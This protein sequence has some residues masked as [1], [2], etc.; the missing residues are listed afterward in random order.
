MELLVHKKREGLREGVLRMGE[1]VAGALRKSIDCLRRQDLELAA[2]ILDEDQPIN[3]HR[4]MLEQ[5]SLVVLAAH[6]PAGRDLRAIGACL[7]LVAELERIA[8]YAA[9][10]AEIVLD[11]GGEVF[12]EEPRGRI[13]SLAEEA[14]AMVT[15]ALS[16]YKDSDAELATAAAG[17][18]D[19]V[20]AQE[21]EIIADLVTLMR[22]NGQLAGAGARLLWAVHLYE[23]VADRATNIAER[24]VFVV[25][26]ETPDLD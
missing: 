20:D 8:D 16:A 1:L 25:S 11:A 12:P 7:E 3:Q 19:A 13:V 14:T 24:V 22:E 10:V 23:R 17:R 18:D 21:K 2:R 15:G 9:D 26:G 6:Q 4:R 5:E